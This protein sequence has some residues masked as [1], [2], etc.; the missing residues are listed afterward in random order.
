MAK[1]SK[2]FDGKVLASLRDDKFLNIR[3]GEEHR[4]LGIWSV[5]VGGRAF[6]RSWNNK[7]TGWYQAFLDNP[8]GAI[9]IG[10]REIPVRVRKVGAAR[11]NDAI[12]LAYLEKFPTKGWKKYAVGL[13][14]PARR[15]TTLELLP[16]A[17]EERRR[18]T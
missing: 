1:T 7:P 13:A 12:D 6:V 10:D 5:V 14:E 15:A 16:R 11:L 4:F 2:R 17:A 9:R 18:R 8:A 3:A